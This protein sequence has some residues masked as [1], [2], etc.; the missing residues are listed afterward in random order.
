MVK[1]P[2]SIYNEYL[3]FIM[4]LYQMYCIKLVLKYVPNHRYFST[5]ERKA[6]IYNGDDHVA[7]PDNQEFYDGLLSE[8]GWRNRSD[9]VVGAMYT[10][11]LPSNH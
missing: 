7:I 11:L 3:V 5:N 4:N 9:K 10:Y 6:R 1:Y 8:L 2:L